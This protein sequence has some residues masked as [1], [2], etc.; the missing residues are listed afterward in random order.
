MTLWKE[1]L[2]LSPLWTFTVTLHGH[3]R[4]CLPDTVDLRDPP[5]WS[6]LAGAAGMG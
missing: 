4:A 1:T 6:T 3:V 5:P 2:M